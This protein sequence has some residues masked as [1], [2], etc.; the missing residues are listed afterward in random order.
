MNNHRTPASAH[1]ADALPLYVN[2]TLDATERERVRAHLDVCAECAAELANWQAV[3]A[4]TQTLVAATPSVAE[5][6]PMQL[7][8]IWAS[9]DALAGETGTAQQPGVVDVA[10]VV[11]VQRA[12]QTVP[13]A[14][15]PTFARRRVW[16]VAAREA[17]AQWA[18]MTLAQARLMRPELWVASVICLAC[19]TFYAAAIHYRGG[20]TTLAVALP[21]IAAGGAAFIYGR[22][23][24]PALEVALAAPISPRAILLSRIGLL[25]GFDGALGVGATA[26]VALTHGEN[27]GAAILLWLGPSAL[28]ASGALLLSL[29]LGPLVSL[30][31]AA[32]VWLAQLVQPQGAQGASGIHF[33]GAPLWGANWQALALTVVFL[34]LAVLYAP[35]QERLT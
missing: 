15:Q 18:W 29:A 33:I 22:E 2:A 14:T 4:A 35:R 28:L 16:W 24:D 34:L 27:V 23:A 26:V 10:D 21:M 20:L 7:D 17:A 3:A 19:V 25:F 5:S 6:A 9:I 1:V 12:V 8:A 13:D 30:A 11:G 31:S 32:G